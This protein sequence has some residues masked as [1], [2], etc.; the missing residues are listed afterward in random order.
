MLLCRN[1][2]RTNVLYA[3]INETIK[4]AAEIDK[5]FE[6]CGL[7][8]NE[9]RLDPWLAKVLTAELLFG[10]KELPGNSKPVQTIL[11]YKDQLEKHTTDQESS[12]IK[13]N[14]FLFLYRS[15][16]T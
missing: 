12:K 5:I 2:Q 6:N 11:S 7:L 10:K 16:A 1:L 3:L 9:P 13:G 8:T 15:N 4:H 14:Y